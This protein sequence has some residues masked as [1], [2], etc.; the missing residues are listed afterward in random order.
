M[1][2]LICDRTGP[3][4]DWPYARPA[5]GP[6]RKL[7]P[8]ARRRARRMRPPRPA[9]SPLKL[10]RGTQAHAGEGLR[11]PLEPERFSR[12]RITTVAG[13]TK[14]WIATSGRGRLRNAGKTRPEVGC[15][16]VASLGTTS[17]RLHRSGSRGDSIHRRRGF[18]S[19][20]E[21]GGAQR[22]SVLPWPRQVWS[23][24]ARA[25][26]SGRTAAASGRGGYP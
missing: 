20:L 19:P 17:S 14:R 3:V 5:Y 1:A 6:A 21:R 24:H 9:G 18:G 26:H 23:F 8:L 12:S 16:A 13:D 2:G 7:H 10:N 22:R 25:R 15:R 4:G 11:S